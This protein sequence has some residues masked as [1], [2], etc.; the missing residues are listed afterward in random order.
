M[1]P[2]NVAAAL[3]ASAGLAVSEIN[4]TLSAAGRPTAAA[5]AAWREVAKACTVDHCRL[6]CR[7]D[8]KDVHDLRTADLEELEGTELRFTLEIAHPGNVVHVATS[9][10]LRR[11]LAALDDLPSVSVVRLL[12]LVDPIR[13]LGV[14]IEPWRDGDGDA[15]PRTAGS[16]PSPRRF[17][18]TIA[19]STK[20]PIEIASWVLE[21]D[22]NRTD[23]AFK[24]WRSFSANA[25]CR[26]LVNEIYDADGAVRVVLAGT[27]TRRLELGEAEV[28][29]ASFA[30]LQGAA[31]WVYVEGPDAELRH[32]LVT[33]ELAR[34]WRD[35]EPFALG[36][37]SRLPAALE[38]AGLAYRA[39]VQQGS[40]DTIK[41]LSDLRKTLAEE[42]G[43]VI[44][45][46]RDLT[47]G[48]WRDVAV[49]IVTIAFRYSMDA[50]KVVAVQPAY[51]LIFVLV[52]AYIVI[53]QVVTV[54]SNRAFFRVGS[55]ARTLWRQKGYAY[56]S[57]D[58]FEELA[59]APLSRARGIYD[60][61]E[62]M[63]S[64]VAGV[65]AAG[66]IASAGWEIGIWQALSRHLATLSCG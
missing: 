42:M 21:G 65:V 63:A 38:S 7:D 8:L 52:A 62:I 9:E 40:K 29:A 12:G 27:P 64:W 1:M 37:G 53:S 4:G 47:S 6:T 3:N 57:N 34:E 50:A 48:L 44:Q 49:A 5:L 15:A 25:V 61:V 31:R 18:R 35:G 11:V 14:Y 51:A 66:L 16:S 20:A 59:G 13:T 39:H 56:L 24:V 23:Q 58:E 41:S 32:T 28:D 22:S 10:G 17:A 45:Q 2:S 30:T 36:I 19:G 60:R 43:K 55:D 26:S 33:N 54:R 46:T